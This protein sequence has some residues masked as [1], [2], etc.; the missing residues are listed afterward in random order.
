[1][2]AIEEQYREET[3]NRRKVADIMGFKYSYISVPNA[4][5]KQVV[6][7]LAADLYPPNKAEEHIWRYLK[8]TRKLS[9]F[10]EYRTIDEL[11]DYLMNKLQGEEAKLD[12][13]CGENVQIPDSID[14]EGHYARIVK[15]FGH[16]PFNEMVKKMFG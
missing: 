14:M 2:T 3:V 10:E 12:S 8:G 9:A 15:E 13:C 4:L 16:L 6:K 11:Y 5:E 1:M 7:L